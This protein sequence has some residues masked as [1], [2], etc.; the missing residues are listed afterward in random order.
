MTALLIH[1]LAAALRAHPAFNA[2]ATDEGFVQVDAINI[3]VAIALD[4][5]LIAPALLRLCRRLSRSRL[6]RPSRT[7]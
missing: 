2:L 7:L 6:P 5:G 3:G 4:D 1:R